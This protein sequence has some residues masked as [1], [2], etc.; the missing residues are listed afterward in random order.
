MAERMHDLGSGT[1]AFAAWMQEYHAP[2][3]DEEDDDAAAGVAQAPVLTLRAQG[4][5][6]TVLC[7]WGPHQT[8]AALEVM[9]AQVCCGS[10]CIVSR[11][12]PLVEN[13]LVTRRTIT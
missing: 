6:D 1:D 11:T 12:A 2:G 9:A 4:L 7:R 13:S 8:L 3:V 10:A 5:L